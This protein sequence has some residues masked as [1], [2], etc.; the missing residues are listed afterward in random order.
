MSAALPAWQIEI[1]RETP[2]PS[3]RRVVLAS[4][5][6]I[7]VGFGGFLGW[8]C[9]AQINTAATATGAI[10]V[11]TKRKTVSLLDPGILK[12]L[13]VREGEAVAAGQPLLKLDDEQILAQL[14][15]FHVQRWTVVARIAR[16]RAEQTERHEIAFPT[17]L[18]AAAASDAAVSELVTNERRVFADRGAVYDGTLAVQRSKIDQSKEQIVAIAAQTEALQQRLAYIEKELAGVVQ[19]LERGLATRTRL[20]EL[21]RNEAELGGNLGELAARK[22]ETRHVIAQTELE[23]TATTNQRRQ[24]ISKDLQDAQSTAADLAEKIRGAED[25]LSK[26]L[27]TAPASGIVTDIKFFTPG[28]SIGAG[29]PVLDIVPQADRLLVE[30]DVRPEDVEHVHPGQPVNIRLTSYK[31]H[32]LPV[33]TGHLTYVSADRQQDA[34]GEFFFLARAQIDNAALDRIKGVSLYPGM[35]AEGLIINGERTAIDYFISPITDSLRR[36]LIEE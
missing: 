29:Q 34:K 35:P 19:L 9:V 16:L 8:A 11:E 25:I 30:L 5:A 22:A 17:D 4:L 33:L 2:T 13:Y 3:L 32:K 24:D 12:T 36:S 15:S 20:Y 28:S 1:E 23:M 14:G 10:V 26:Q 21:K 31:Q 7:V 6:V 27:V 18:L